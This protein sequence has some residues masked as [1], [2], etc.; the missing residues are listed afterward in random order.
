MAETT[1]TP[2]AWRRRSASQD[3]VGTL[4]ATDLG[5]RLDGREPSTGIE[6]SLSIPFSEIE[7]VGAATGSGSVV[8][9]LA[10]SEP[11]LLRGVENGFR[12]LGDLGELVARLRAPAAG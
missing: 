2:V 9:H 10:G 4:A 8:L 12:T 5:L 1:Q 6:L 7:A 3:Y 11:V